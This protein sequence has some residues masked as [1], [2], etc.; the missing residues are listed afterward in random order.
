MKRLLKR[1]LLTCPGFEATC[2]LLTA[3]TVRTLMYHRFIADFNENIHFVDAASLRRQ[4]AYLAQ[5]HARWRPDDIL[6]ARNRLRPPGRCPVVVTVDDGYRDFYE[7]AYPI[8]RDYDIPAMLFVITG[9]VDGGLWL[10]WDRLECML[11]Q[12]PNA[13]GLAVDIGGQTLLLDLHHLDGRTAAWH[14]VTDLCRF[15]ADEQ[16]EA[17]LD[18]LASVLG[19]SL[20]NEPHLDYAPVTWEQIRT[21]A[22]DG[23]LM[24]AHTITHPILS[25]VTPERARWELAGSRDRLAEMTGAI[26]NWFSYPQGESVDFTPEVRDLVAEAGFSGCFVAYQNL[27]SPEDAYALP[28]SSVSGDMTTFRWTLCGA[29]I[30]WLRLRRRLGLATDPSGVYWTASS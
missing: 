29:E 6:A 20:S 3:R 15:M 24:G 27:L 19:A 13:R 17:T 28:R 18:D 22:A 16:K 10:W 5:Y 30:L 12:A 9:F 4:A 7:V 25:R 14:A 1:L 21:M 2:R 8:F 23:M 26:P 11:A